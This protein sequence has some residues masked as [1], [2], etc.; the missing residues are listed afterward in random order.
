[1]TGTS[2][3]ALLVEDNPADVAL[4][5]E[6]I[7]DDDAQSWQIKHCSYLFSAIDQLS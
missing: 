5:M 3:T 2:I 1:M 4:L 6:H 7:Q